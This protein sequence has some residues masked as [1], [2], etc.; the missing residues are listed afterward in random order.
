MQVQSLGREDPS[1]EEMAN[2]LQYSCLEYPMGGGVCQGLQRA[3]HD[4]ATEH[5]PMQIHSLKLSMWLYLEMED[6]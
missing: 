2:L 4:L 3:W 6:N 5:E 1:E